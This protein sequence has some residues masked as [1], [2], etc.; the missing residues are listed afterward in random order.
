MR[1][2]APHSAV[3]PLAQSRK[4]RATRRARQADRLISPQRKK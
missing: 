4:R 2:E 1:L 3:T